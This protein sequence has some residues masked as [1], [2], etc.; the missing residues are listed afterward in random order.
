MKHAAPIAEYESVRQQLATML[1]P[2]MFGDPAA[3]TGAIFTAVDADEPPL[4]LVLG[5][6]LPM[7]RQIYADRLASWEKWE[8]VSNAAQGSRTQ[9]RST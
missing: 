6:L 5:S 2:E 1:T 7:I 4:Q 9:G 8:A 3:T